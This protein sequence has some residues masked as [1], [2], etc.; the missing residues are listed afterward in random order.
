[1]QPSVEQITC[2]SSNRIVT[3]RPDHRWDIFPALITRPAS[4]SIAAGDADAVRAIS[5]VLRCPVWIVTVTVCPAARR[6]SAVVVISATLGSVSRDRGMYQA[7][8]GDTDWNDDTD[9]GG[10]AE[11]E[12]I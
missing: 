8:Y 4:A 2:R 6:F 7:A 9:D 5:A 12:Q 10:Y 3:G 11:T 1:M